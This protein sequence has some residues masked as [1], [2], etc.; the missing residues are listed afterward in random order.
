MGRLTM[1]GIY[2]AGHKVFIDTGAW[3]ALALRHDKYHETAKAVFKAMVACR[4]VQVTSNLVIS[5]TYT[6]IRYN[7]NYHTAL[8]FLESIKKAENM[9]F[10]QVV[11]S[12]PE[13]EREALRLIKKYCD[14]TISYVDAVSFV[15]L[16]QQPDIKDV[17]TFDSHFFL[18]SKNI[19]RAD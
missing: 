1:T 10:L 17:F 18:T 7:V 16:K 3:I 5:E 15:I 4:V 11:Y 13:I 19:L 9:N 12:T 2:M 14:Q 8:R 6:F